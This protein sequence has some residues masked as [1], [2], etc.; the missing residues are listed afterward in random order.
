VR[1][2]SISEAQRITRSRWL[3]F[4]V[5]LMTAA[6][7]GL[8]AIYPLRTALEALAAVYTY[9]GAAALLLGGLLSAAGAAWDRWSGEALGLPLCITAYV[10]FGGVLCLGGSL[11]G[12]AIGLLFLGTGLLHVDRWSHVMYMLKIAGREDQR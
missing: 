4:M 12:V 11:A 2:L 7:G 5:Y 1:W 9:G 3:R 10:L 6:A 8:L